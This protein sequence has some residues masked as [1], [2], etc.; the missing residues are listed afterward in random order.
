M[1]IRDRA[2][3]E[4]YNE[5]RTRNP[6][7]KKR[8]KHEKKMAGGLCCGSGWRNCGCVSVY[9]NGDDGDVSGR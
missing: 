5:I 3:E 4:L 1:C 6:L 7:Q 9:G 2:R 8:E